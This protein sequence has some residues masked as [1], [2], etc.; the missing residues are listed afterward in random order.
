MNRRT[1]TTRVVPRRSARLAALVEQ[2]EDDAVVGEEVSKCTENA[3]HDAIIKARVGRF[4]LVDEDEEMPQETFV[5]HPPVEVDAISEIEP[6]PLSRW[7]ALR[8]DSNTANN[9]MTVRYLDTMFDLI[10]L[11]SDFVCFNYSF[12]RMQQAW[13]QIYRRMSIIKLVENLYCYHHSEEMKCL[14]VIYR[15][16]F[17]TIIC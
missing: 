11:Y 9:F 10:L 17:H 1:K 4:E 14:R 15:L 5:P 16:F 13:L 2:D 7:R 6:I 3:C 8:Y 12:N